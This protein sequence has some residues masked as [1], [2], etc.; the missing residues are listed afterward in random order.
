[1]PASEKPIYNLEWIPHHMG[2]HN[3]CNFNVLIQIYLSIYSELKT[4]WG[5][6]GQNLWPLWNPNYLKCI[7]DGCVALSCL[8]CQ[9]L[10][11]FLA[12]SDSVLVYYLH[13][14]FALQHIGRVQRQFNSRKTISKSRTFHS[15]FFFHLK[16]LTKVVWSCWRL[17]WFKSKISIEE[18]SKQFTRGHCKCS[19]SS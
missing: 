8:Q 6:L 4:E 1:M 7:L 14:S 9:E 17:S 16:F 13:V 12:F 11:V 15:V 10:Y 19:I 5:K 18:N 2:L 3:L